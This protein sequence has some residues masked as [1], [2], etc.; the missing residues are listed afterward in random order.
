MNLVFYKTISEHNK[1][2][3]VLT[4]E[5]TIVGNIQNDIDI[6]NPVFN[7]SL[8]NNVVDYNYCYIE[9]FNRYY[10]ITKIEIV[11]KMLR[12]YMHIDVLMSFKNDIL[13]SKAHI[14]RSNRGNL[15][16][17]DSMAYTTAKPVIQFKNLG[18]CFTSQASYI[19]VKGG[20]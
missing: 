16:L 19:M 13:N 9:A 3:K 17:K 10:Y 2:N 11:N 12:V 4:A 14:T 1:L 20:Q 18:T 7:I 8:E 6:D 15:F 5:K